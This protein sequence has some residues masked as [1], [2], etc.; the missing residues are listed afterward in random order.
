[1]RE[2]R[3]EMAKPVGLW[4]AYVMGLAFAFG[5]TPCIGPILAAILAVAAS[6][7]T[8]AQGRRPAGGLFARAR[9][10]VSAGGVCGRAVRRSSSRAFAA[11]SP[12]SRR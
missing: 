3:V 7:Q 6:E 8:V 11:I 5:W 4:G 9:H 1:M 10:P 2:K 12:R